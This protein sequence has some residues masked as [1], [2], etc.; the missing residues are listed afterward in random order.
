[1]AH[2]IETTAWA[3]TEPWH[4]LGEKVSNNLSAEQMLKAAG[5]DWTVS[6]RPIFHKVGDEMQVIDKEFVLAR[7]KDNAVLSLT[8]SMYKPVQNAD[9]MEFFKKFVTEAKMT[10][11]TAGSLWGGRYIWG[12]ARVGKDFKLDKTDEV[13]S[14]LLLC[15]PHVF[16]KAMTI[17]FT[18]I[19]VVC[20]NTLCFALGESLKGNGSAFRMPH[21]VEFTNGVKEQAA[22]A[23]GLATEQMAEFK[24]AATLLNK[25]KAEKKEVEEFFCEVLR[26]D[27]KTAEKKKDGEEREPKML[28]RFR[29]ALVHAPGQ[30]LGVGTWWSAVNAVTYTVDHMTGRERSTALRSAWLGGRAE[31]KRRAFNIALEKAK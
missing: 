10:M 19:R 3:T 26:F 13:R 31:L 25:A 20:W 7:D 29:E 4:G 21:S 14:Y 6:K 28:P 12:L 8:G 2:N 1:M 9:A 27:P 18:S 22:V 5:L 23:L 17:Q 15:Q 11:E 30:N 16:G 24:E